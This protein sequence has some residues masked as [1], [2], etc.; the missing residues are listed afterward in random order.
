MVIK[1]KPKPKRKPGVKAH[2]TR[3]KIVQRCLPLFEAKGGRLRVPWVAKAC[4]VFP[5]TILS[6]FKGG[7]EEIRTEMTRS[8]LS[9]VAAPFKPGQ[10][11]D[12]YLR[13]L[14]W[15]T[16]RRFHGRRCVAALLGPELSANNLLNPLLAERVLAALSAAG[17]PQDQQVRG[18]NF[19]LAALIGFI[20]I[21][22]PALGAPPSAGWPD[23]IRKEIDRLPDGEFPMLKAA[24]TEL[25][26]DAAARVSQ[27]TETEPASDRVDLFFAHVKTVI[28]S[29]KPL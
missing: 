21:E 1:I 25:K 24:A 12:D 23:H 9:G 29:L 8:V 4:N 10:G 7:V 15:E 18:L 5:T 27:A 11:W 3:G 13:D 19:V 28:D 20:A 22:I 16:R 26:A 2:L 6:H 17:V 14:F